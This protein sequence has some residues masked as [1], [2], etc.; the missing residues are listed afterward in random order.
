VVKEDSSPGSSV[1]C[2]S[3]ESLFARNRCSSPPRLVDDDTLA[4]RLE[5]CYGRGIMVRGLSI[6]E[7]ETIIRA[8][9]D[10]PDGFEELRASKSTNADAPEGIR[11]RFRSAAGDTTV[12]RSWKHGNTHRGE[13]L[14]CC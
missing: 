10:P 14:R 2:S 3:P 7:R 12:W 1:G 13:E 5:D 8:L 9:D 11:A 4:T 6:A